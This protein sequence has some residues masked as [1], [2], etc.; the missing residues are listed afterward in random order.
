MIK[1]F[2]SNT[3][4]SVQF[5]LSD[6]QALLLSEPKLCSVHHRSAVLTVINGLVDRGFLERGAHPLF[7]TRTEAGAAAL[8]LF[9]HFGG[10]IADKSRL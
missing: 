2:Q 8:L 7:F 1:R 3:S 9:Q 10:V 4:I 6:L 5:R